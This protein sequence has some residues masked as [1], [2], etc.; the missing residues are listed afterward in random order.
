MLLTDRGQEVGDALMN[1]VIHRACSAKQP[2]F[3]DLFFIFFVNT[4]DKIS[5][6]DRAAENI[7][8]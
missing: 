8:E 3:K 4:E 1:G 7:H 6:A 2:A 5:F